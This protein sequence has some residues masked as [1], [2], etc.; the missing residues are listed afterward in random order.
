MW[1]LPLPLT[2][3]GGSGANLHPTKDRRENMCLIVGVTDVTLGQ[4]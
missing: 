2:P 1:T 4:R 3:G